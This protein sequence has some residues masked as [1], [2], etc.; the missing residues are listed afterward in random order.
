MGSKTKAKAK[1]AQAAT[2]RAFLLVALLCGSSMVLGTFIGWTTAGQFRW[3]G[4]VGLA[5]TDAV[6]FVWTMSRLRDLWEER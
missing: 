5:L 2:R 1:A 3:L 6:V 4:L